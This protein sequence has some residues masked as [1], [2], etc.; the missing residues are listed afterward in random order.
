MKYI[1]IF[2]II[3]GGLLSAMPIPLIKN[4]IKTKNIIWIILSFLCYS[5]LIIVYSILLKNENSTIIYSIIKVSSILLVM[6]YDFFIL[7]QIFNTTSILGI[8]FAITSVLL[9][10]SNA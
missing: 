10:S 7:K 6:T 4:Y 5:I 8:F 9:L 2:L 3:I 1:N